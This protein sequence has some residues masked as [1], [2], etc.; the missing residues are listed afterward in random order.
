MKFTR[1]KRMKPLETVE[2]R[3]ERLELLKAVKEKKK[4]FATFRQELDKKSFMGTVIG[5]FQYT[6]KR[7]KSETVR[8]IRELEYMYQRDEL[9][10]KL[11]DFKRNR[12]ER[13]IDRSLNTI[14]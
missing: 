13:A 10:Q 7:S 11:L 14:Y 8:S 12:L 1:K 3:K 5:L 9:K 4:E 6:F 2:E